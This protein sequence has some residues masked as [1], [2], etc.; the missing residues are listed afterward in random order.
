MLQNNRI[1]RLDA[2]ILLSCESCIDEEVNEFYDQKI[3]HTMSERANRRILRMIR[4][5]DRARKFAPYKRPLLIA[6]FAVMLAITLSFVACMS[7]PKVRKAI[8][9]AITEWHDDYISVKFVPND[10]EGSTTET[11]EG[12]NPTTEHG[13]DEPDKTS[14]TTDKPDDPPVV[15]ID[16]PKTIEEINA[17]T[18]V[19]EGYTTDST[20]LKM[21]YTV[22]Y[23][24]NDELLIVFFQK[25]IDSEEEI[26]YDSEYAS[27]TNTVI[28]G[29]EAILVSYSYPD[30]PN[31]YTLIWRDCRYIYSI[32]GVFDTIEDI[33]TLASSVHIFSS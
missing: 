19:P 14:T 12:T 16:P 1:D 32:E 24:K 13:T 21:F 26:K 11:T 6:A 5:Y 8:W 10:D 31:V 25:I 27:V 9:K 15:H 20:E 3:E 7:I 28:N 17:P 33:F 18:Y 22:N 2:L 30:M 23:Y 4:R 29:V